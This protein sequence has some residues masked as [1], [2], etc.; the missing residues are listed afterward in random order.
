MQRELNCLLEAQLRR[1]D[2][3]RSPAFNQNEAKASGPANDRQTVQAKPT[4]VLMFETAEQAK[5][6]EHVLKMSEAKPTPL[7]R[8]KR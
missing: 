8:A 2:W 4:V 3:L 1:E 5:A 7:G 6:A